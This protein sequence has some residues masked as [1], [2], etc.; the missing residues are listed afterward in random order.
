M[1][2]PK[3]PRIALI[4][5]LRGLA[6][7]AMATYHFTWDLG[8]FGYLDPGTAT[9]GFFRIYAR[10]IASTFLFLAGVSLVLAHMPTIR[11]P[12]FWRRFAMV[13]GAALLISVGT[14]IAFPGEWIYFGILHNIA[15]SSLIGLALSLIHI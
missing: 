8:F 7:I 15:V 11:W 1:V 13:A 6:L 10:S 9:H 3:V 2:M 12:S 14:F 5:S 4:D